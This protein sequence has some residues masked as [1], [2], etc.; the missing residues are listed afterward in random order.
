MA[1]QHPGT[2]AANKIQGLRATLD[3]RRSSNTLARF[4]SQHAAPPISACHHENRGRQDRL[5]L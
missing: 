3:I 5:M 1:V 2:D 4:R